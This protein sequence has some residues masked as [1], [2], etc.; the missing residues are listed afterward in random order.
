[1]PKVLCIRD[2]KTALYERPFTCR[3]IG[4]A[5]RD[6]GT[7]C[8]NKETKYGLYPSDFELYQVG[9]FDD[10]TG[11]LIPMNPIHLDSGSNYGTSNS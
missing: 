11:A 6:F 8:K 9:E 10:E 4:E 1:M 2:V 3:H 5:L 7:L